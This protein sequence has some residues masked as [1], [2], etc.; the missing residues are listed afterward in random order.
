MIQ[1]PTIETVETSALIPYARNARTHSENQIDQ[2]AASIREFGFNNPILVKDDLTVI[3]GHGRLEAAKKLGLAEVPVIKLGHLSPTQIRAYILA[4]NKLALNAGWDDEM[5][6]LELSDLKEEKVDLE[7]LGFSKDETDTLLGLLTAEGTEL[8][9]LSSDERPPFQ[10]KT[11]ILHNEQI[12]EVDAAIDEVKSS[13]L[14]QSAVNEN[15]NGNAL[16]YICTFF[17]RREKGEN[18]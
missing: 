5:L 18:E 6:A 2:I 14:A 4:D 15:S 10:Q 17:N 12:E 3:A 16:A 1:K 9:E 8:P 7:L 11:F 13:G